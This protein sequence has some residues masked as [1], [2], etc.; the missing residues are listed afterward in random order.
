MPA[1]GIFAGSVATYILRDSWRSQVLSG[2]LPAL[3]LLLY[4]T[5]SCESPRWLI[6]QNRYAK[7]YETLV[8]LRGERVLAA[9]E[10]CFIH[11]Q[12]QVERWL[13]SGETDMD[14]ESQGNH[15]DPFDPEL[16]RTGYFKRLANL[17]LF[18]RNRR[19]AVAA[20]IVMVSQQ[21]SGVNI[22]AFLAVRTLTEMPPPE[23]K[24]EG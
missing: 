24:Y 23:G 22:Y 5:A 12:V 14:L 13:F 4:T 2:A 10:L 21:L 8:R 6:T 17:W 19:A 15:N 3:L 7:A 18:S 9:K 16:P 20:M 11:Y 1:T